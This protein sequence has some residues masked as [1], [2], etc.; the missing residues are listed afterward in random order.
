MA[1]QMQQIEGADVS[2]EGDQ[3]EILGPGDQHHHSRHVH[4]SKV[5]P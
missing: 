5:N 2:V 1:A 3:V 4:V